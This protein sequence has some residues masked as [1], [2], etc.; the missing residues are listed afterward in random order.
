MPRATWRAN[1]GGLP[2]CVPVADVPGRDA[3]WAYLGPTDAQRMS[4]LRVAVSRLLYTAVTDRCLIDSAKNLTD[5]TDARLV[6][7]VCTL[8]GGPPEY[9]GCQYRDAASLADLW[10]GMRTAHRR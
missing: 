6:A 10:E 3:L 4:N 8:F 5:G 2:M 9:P 1:H 7:F